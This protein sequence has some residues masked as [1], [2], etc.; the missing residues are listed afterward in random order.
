MA[1][2]PFS[3]IVS[4]YLD[5]QQILAVASDRIARSFSMSEAHQAVALDKSKAFRRVW[6]AGHLHKIKSYGIS[7]YVFGLILSS[8][9]HRRLKMLLDGKSSK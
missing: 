1:F 9:S 7:G 8:L 2:C 4:A 6:H 5:Q 3:N